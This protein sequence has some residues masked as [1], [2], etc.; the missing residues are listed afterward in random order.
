MGQ[1][2]FIE[3][4]TLDLLSYRSTLG[5]SLKQISLRHTPLERILKDI[6]QYREGYINTIVVEQQ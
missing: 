5:K 2:I 1:N 6:A 4:D 3:Q